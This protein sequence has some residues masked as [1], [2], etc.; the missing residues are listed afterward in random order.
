MVHV[1]LFEWIRYE[2]WSRLTTDLFKNV[3]THEQVG[4]TQFSVAV[5][6]CKF[7]LRLD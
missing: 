7:K 4:E 1:L 6:L 3:K 5:E 2:G